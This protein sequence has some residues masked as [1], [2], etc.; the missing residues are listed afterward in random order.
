MDNQ[1]G[2]RLREL[3]KGLGLT[4][5]E[6]A[7]SMTERFP[8]QTKIIGNTL[9]K[10]E[11]GERQTSDDTL[12]MLASF[13]GVSVEYLQGESVDDSVIRFLMDYYNEKDHD[14]IFW[15]A[16]G[17]P[18]S[19]WGRLENYFIGNGIVS[20]DVP[21]TTRLLSEDQ[22]ADFEFWKKQ[23]SWL[24]DGESY[25]YIKESYGK[26]SESAFATILATT[27]AANNEVQVYPDV[28]YK[29]SS[30]SEWVVKNSEFMERI[31]K[32]QKFL[33]ANLVPNDE[34][35]FIDPYGKP[36]FDWSFT[37]ELGLPVEEIE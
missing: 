19:L 8:G 17:F 9:S 7:K 15:Q 30:S 31:I 22:A 34:P 12:R 14:R 2:N 3:R 23:F 27:I 1:I 26:A 37:W 10:Y 35:D 4:L 18:W 24:I 20:Y 11:K 5:N 28:H 13:Y 6:A 33:N 29:D 21:N 16:R 32:R 36:H 25:K